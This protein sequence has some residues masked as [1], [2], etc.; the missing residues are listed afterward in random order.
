MVTKPKSNS[1]LT[2]EVN[3]NA[4]TFNVLEVGTLRLDFS[5]L[6]SA[7]IQR[8]AM[9]GM[10]QRISDAAA[11]SRDPTTG[12]SATPEA[13]YTAMK[14]LVDHY[15]SGTSEWRTA[16]VGGAGR[17]SNLLPALVKLY[18]NRSMVELAEWLASKSKEEKS[19]LRNSPKIA[20]IL[21]EMA[22]GNGDEILGELE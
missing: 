1:V 17:V 16:K 14:A 19:A 18:P 6:N 9:H 22:G 8:A 10:I 11:I 15:E 5:K 21:A 12:Q 7:I 20:Q 4:V 3:D 13:K 2:H